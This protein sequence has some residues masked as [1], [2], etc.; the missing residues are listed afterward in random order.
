MGFRTFRS[1]KTS[2]PV[3]HE[4]K[5]R[6]ANKTTIDFYSWF[7]LTIKFFKNRKNSNQL[8]SYFWI[9]FNLKKYCKIL[10][11]Y[12]MDD[13][14]FTHEFHH[15]SHLPHRFFLKFHQFVILTFI[16]V[17]KSFDFQVYVSNR[18]ILPNLKD[19]LPH[20]W[21]FFLF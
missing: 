12:F 4:T 21:W 13:E 16:K 9:P 18:I 15:F 20:K 5:F 3:S 1:R 2:T 14:K 6:S 17:F 10:F 11:I 8:W 7:F 19:Y